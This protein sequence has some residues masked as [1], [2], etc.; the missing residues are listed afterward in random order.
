MLSAKLIAWC[1]LAV[2]TAQCSVSDI[3]DRRISNMLVVTTFGAG[4]IW[5]ASNGVD[6]LVTAGLHAGIAL[7]AGMFLFRQGIIGGGDAKFYAAVAMWFPFAASLRLLVAVALSGLVLLAVFQFVRRHHRAGPAQ[8]RS[9]DFDRLPYGVAIGAGG[10]A[11][12]LLP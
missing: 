1:I 7:V 5:S 10:L 9:V 4:V 8:A 3:R 2:L 11:A 12:F 6:V